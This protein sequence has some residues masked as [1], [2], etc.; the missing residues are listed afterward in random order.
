[1][2]IDYFY[3]IFKF[4]V[5]SQEKERRPRPHLK[6]QAPEPCSDFWRQTGFGIWV[7]T[8]VVVIDQRCMVADF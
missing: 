2:P 1:M 7:A 5:K 4:V 3:F 6:N 8:G